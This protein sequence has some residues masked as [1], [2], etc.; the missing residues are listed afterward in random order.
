MFGHAPKAQGPWGVLPLHC[1]AP[2]M[3]VPWCRLRLSFKWYEWVM[4]SRA[5]N[6][7]V[8]HVP[9]TSTPQF[10]NHFG[11]TCR[12]FLLRVKG[13]IEKW[14]LSS[15]SWWAVASSLYNVSL[16]V[17]LRGDTGALRKQVEPS[18]QRRVAAVCGEGPSLCYSSKNGWTGDQ[19][20][21][22]VRA[23]TI[24]CVSFLSL[25][26]SSVRLAN[27]WNSQDATNT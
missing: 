1:F 10:H 17:S 26:V 12:S 4:A 13:V 27:I 5:E 7:N 20:V 14:G 2:Q 22:S 8:D 18:S 24:Y 6:R 15:I 9:L 21:S 19:I 11:W 3:G 23:G 25:I 16:V